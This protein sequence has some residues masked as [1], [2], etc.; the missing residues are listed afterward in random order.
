LRLR[1]EKNRQVW[2]IE[3]VTFWRVLASYW[4]PLSTEPCAGSGVV[5]NLTRPAP[6]CRTGVRRWAEPLTNSVSQPVDW[7]PTARKYLVHCG[8]SFKRSALVAGLLLTYLGMK[9]SGC[10]DASE[11]KRPGA[12][13][14]Q[15]FAAYLTALR[16]N[17]TL[18]CRLVANVRKCVPDVNR[19]NLLRQAKLGRIATH[20]AIALW[21]SF[22]ARMSS[23]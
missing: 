8:M 22:R 13:F 6:S 15:N 19:E 17:C 18:S 3:A 9:E 1:I 14:N 4:L 10:H 7:W 23:V 20:S 12:L 5:T 16:P 11:G 21:K 2:P